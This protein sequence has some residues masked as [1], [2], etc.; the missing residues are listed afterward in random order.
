[1]IQPRQIGFKGDRMSMISDFTDLITSRVGCGY[2][3]GSQGE[4]MTQDRLNQLVKQFGRE[5]YFGTDKNASQWVGKQCFD[6]SGLVVWAL[7][8]M[9]ILKPA[10]DYA[11][12]GIYEKLCIP[13]T[14]EGLKPGDLCFVKGG[15]KDRIDHVGIYAGNNQVVHARGTKY[16]VVK[17]G[18]LP[19][20]GLFG[21]LKALSVDEL[22]KALEFIGAKSGIDTNHW[23]QQAKQ[24]KW[25][26]E[27]FIKIAKGFGGM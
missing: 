17:T 15:S 11:A 6:C 20:F 16:G 8:Q 19:Y 27:C 18:V 1:M 23:Y 7:Q 4:I 14:R 10:E 5:H 24:V 12:Q 2:A 26:D 9:T 21:Q 3:Y 13:S 22:K 25:L